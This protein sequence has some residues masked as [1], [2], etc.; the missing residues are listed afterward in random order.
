MFIFVLT[1]KLWLSD[2]MKN[3]SGHGN[4]ILITVVQ[5]LSHSPLRSYQVYYLYTRHINGF[6]ATLDEEVVD[7]I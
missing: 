7:D 5:V 4:T 2:L 3:S 6:A 1:V